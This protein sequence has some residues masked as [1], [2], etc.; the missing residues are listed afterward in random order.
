MKFFMRIPIAIPADAPRDEP[1][2]LG[3]WAV[4]VG[5]TVEA[6]DVLA[7]L[8]CPG[9]ALELVAPAAGVV[10]ELIRQPE[11]SV[12]AGEVLGWMESAPAAQ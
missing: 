5:D 12:S 8:I 7:E 6:G 11:Q 3:E 2:R 9:L 10:A 1:L 4:E